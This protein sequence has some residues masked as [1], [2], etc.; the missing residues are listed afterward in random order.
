MAAKRGKRGWG[1]A[2][3]V[4]LLAGPPF[5]G[6]CSS[7]PGGA[8]RFTLFPDRGTL[9]EKTKTVRQPASPPAPVPRELA[10][11]VLP[12]YTV[13]PGDTLSVNTA[14]PES[15]IQFQFGGDQPILPDGTINLG[16]FGQVIV[17][18]K[19]L[20]DIEALVRSVVKAQDKDPG[21][22]VV[23]IGSRMSKVYY[24]LGEVNN[25]G[26][27]QLQGRETVLDGLM[28]AGGLT[29]RASRVNIVLSRPTAPDSCRV[30][31]PVCYREI[32]Q[33]GDTTTNYQLAPGDRIYVAGK[34]FWESLCG[35][36]NKHVQSPC[37]CDEQFPCPLSP[38]EEHA[39]PHTG[40]II[41]PVGSEPPPPTDVA[42]P[43]SG[44]GATPAA[45]VLPRHSDT[46]PPVSTREAL[47]PPLAELP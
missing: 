18:G 10:Q 41:Q 15:P 36:D 3:V 42:P 13:E 1:W 29:D 8:T 32:V 30:V 43:P 33:I 21:P 31:L 23:R 45:R 16:K 11:R 38:H 9:M 6:G 12:P 46:A 17:A 34:G 20:R 37:N 39:P 35:S 44:P 7:G 22:I 19:T 26:A 2:L 14:D 28:A 4:G 40:P 24:V 47:G 27:F 5:L 25:P